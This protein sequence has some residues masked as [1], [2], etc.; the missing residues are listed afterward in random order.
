MLQRKVQT[1]LHVTGAPTL[2]RNRKSRG[3]ANVADPDVSVRPYPIE[4]QDGVMA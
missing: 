4:R 2:E 1:S 3:E